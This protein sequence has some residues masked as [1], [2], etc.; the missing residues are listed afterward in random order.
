MIRNYMKSL[1][2]GSAAWN[3]LKRATDELQ[4]LRIDMDDHV[5]A[6]LPGF[7]LTME[8]ERDLWGRKIVHTRV[9]SPYN[10]N[11]VDQELAYLDKG[12]KSATL[13][14]H[15]TNL[16]GEIGLEAEEIDGST[17][18]PERWHSRFWSTSSTPTVRLILLICRRRLTAIH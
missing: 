18:A 15:P 4:R 17:N 12:Q 16:D 10:P 14:G 11:V 13:S 7:S 6:R 9:A 2:P 1:V 3:E 8:P 5:R